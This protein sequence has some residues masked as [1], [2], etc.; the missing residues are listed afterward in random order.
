[1]GPYL[2]V[3]QYQSAFFNSKL[4]FFSRRTISEQLCVLGI[5][6][7]RLSHDWITAG[8]QRNVQEKSSIPRMDHPFCNGVDSAHL[9]VLL[10]KASINVYKIYSTYPIYRNYTRE[11]A[12]APGFHLINIHEKSYPAHIWLYIFCGILDSMWQTTGMWILDGCDLY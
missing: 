7:Y 4:L 10:S 3:S 1:M 9:G 2:I 11:S 8:L 6:N 12:S 5:S